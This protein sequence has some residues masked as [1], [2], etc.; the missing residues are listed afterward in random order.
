MSSKLSQIFKN[1]PEISP[2]SGLEERVFAAV[3][4]EK[5][6]VIKRELM[7]SRFGLGGSLVA[8]LVAIFTL[9]GAI[10]QS[11]FFSI[12][13]LAFSDVSIVATHWQ[14]FAYSV[15]ENFPTISVVAIL[16]PVLTALWSLSLYFNFKNKNN[17]HQYHLIN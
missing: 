14:E 12:V 10:L 13:S 5:D 2:S 1:M 3:Q 8:F 15:A 17:F 7:I 4:L 6:R 11:E 9:G 16:I